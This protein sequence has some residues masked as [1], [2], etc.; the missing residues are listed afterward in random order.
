LFL[1]KSAKLICTLT[2]FIHLLYPIY[3]NFF[4]AIHRKTC[5]YWR[6]LCQVNYFFKKLEKHNIWRIIQTYLLH[7]VFSKAM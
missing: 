6:L 3:P 4:N 1:Y 5:D 7:I 2:K